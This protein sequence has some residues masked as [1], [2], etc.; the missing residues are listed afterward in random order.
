MKYVA[1]AD[2]NINL[3]T[4]N[5]C[6]VTVKLYKGKRYSINGEYELKLGDVE[7]RLTPYMLGTYFNKV[8]LA[9]AAAYYS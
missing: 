5:N 4:A 2:A 8:Y 9:D 1:N 3:N 6:R 7:V